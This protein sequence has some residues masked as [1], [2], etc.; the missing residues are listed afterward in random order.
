MKTEFKVM[1]WLREVRDRHARETEGLTSAERVAA[2]ERETHAWTT[3]FL[4]KHPD[5]AVRAAP[6]HARVAET[7]ESYGQKPKT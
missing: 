6:A 1:P 7:S 4:R 3:A 5:T 2:L